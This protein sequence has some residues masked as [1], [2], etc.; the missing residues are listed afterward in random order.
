MCILSDD[1]EKLRMKEDLWKYV[2]D[3]DKKLYK[4][5]RYSM[6]GWSVNI[7]TAAG[8]KISKIGYK[9]FNKLIGFN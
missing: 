1:K 2:K 9:V 6:L 4:M 3:K 8:R 5:L 7:P